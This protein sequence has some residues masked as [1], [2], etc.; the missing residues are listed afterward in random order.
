M[1]SRKGRGSLSAEVILATH[2]PGKLREFQELLRQAPFVIRALETQEEII[3]ETGS[4]YLENARLK[5]H[6]VARTYGLPA[7]ADDSGVEVDA[8]GGLPG[9]HSARFVSDVPWINSREILVRLMAVPRSERTARMR[10]VVVLA[11][12]DGRDVWAEGVVEG[13]IVG[14]PRGQEGFGIDPIF[15]ADG[16]R[17]LAEIPQSVKNRIS[18]RYLATRALIEK[19]DSHELWR[20]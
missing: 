1:P 16:I 6:Y 4:T 17:T 2:N 14:W 10:A 12:P 9:I 7:L 3:E 15:T 11:W 8:L 19:I 5:A 13:E 20:R 18:H